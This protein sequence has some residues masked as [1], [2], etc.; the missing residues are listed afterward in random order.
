MLN[1]IEFIHDRYNKHAVLDDNYD[2]RFDNLQDNL[3][4][5]TSLVENYISYLHYFGVFAD[6][7]V[8]YKE[9][10]KAE[11]SDR[12]EDTLDNIM[13]LCIFINRESNNIIKGYNE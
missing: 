1:F 6:N 9:Q 11:L 4:N 3:F 5:D 8:N 10:L 7:I 12:D 13:H 2:L